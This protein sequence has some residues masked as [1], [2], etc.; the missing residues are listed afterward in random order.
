MN[1][2][3]GN[4]S[5]QSRGRRVKEDVLRQ[6]RHFASL[7]D[8]TNRH[9]VT[10]LS[11]IRYSHIP[12]PP[13]HPPPLQ[14]PQ[15]RQPSNPVTGKRQSQK[16]ETQP[17][18]SRYFEETLASALDEEPRELSRDE[19]EA[20][21]ESKRRLL[22]RED[23]AGLRM[24]MPINVRFASPVQGR[25]KS[26]RAATRQRNPRPSNRHLTGSRYVEM[27]RTA[28]GWPYT[29]LHTGSIKIRIG[30]EISSHLQHSSAVQ[31][32][33]PTVAHRRHSLAPHGSRVV[34]PF[35]YMDTHFS[36]RLTILRC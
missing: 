23:W 31:R 16:N 1:W 9:S 36:Q 25:R 33:P 11:P 6:K 5:R 29:S 19:D 32:F 3:G 7:R 22:A 2:S 17:W 26:S 35:L 4:L 15:L 13:A 21:Q 18:A 28:P 34:S 30:D 14:Q 10:R 27:G 8:G 20:L 12:S 24:Q